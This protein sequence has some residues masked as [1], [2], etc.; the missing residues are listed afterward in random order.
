[1][2]SYRVLTLFLAFALAL[3]ACNLPTANASP[4][5][6]ANAIFTAAAQTVEVK[7]TENAAAIP[8]ATLPAPS[9]TPQPVPPANTPLPPPPVVITAT[10]APIVVQPTAACDAARFVK[11]VTI[12]DGTGFTG[13]ATFTKTWRLQNAGICTWSTAYALSFDSGTQMGGPSTQPL[14][15][16]V[17]PGATVD[18]AVNLQAPNADG[19]Y[20]GV[21]GLINGSGVRMPVYGGISGKSFTVVIKVGSGVATAGPTPV[22]G[23]TPSVFAVTSVNISYSP[24]GSCGTASQKFNITALITANR[25]GTV[26]YHWVRSDPGSEPHHTLT[27]GSA[28]TQTVTYEWD[29]A[30]ASGLSMT[31]YIDSPN[32]QLLPSVP[33]ALTCP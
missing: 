3:G 33:V 29:T 1:M 32:H 8:S 10:S 30:F 24:S 25:S 17:A 21:W 5:V 11:D 12:D 16:P 6:N 23:A 2:K 28:G 15:G 13:G 14:I 7:L 20:T 26:E 4:T 27:F 9:N 31:M 19:N 18:I 22:G